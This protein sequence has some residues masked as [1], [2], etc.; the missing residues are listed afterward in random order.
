MAIFGWIGRD[1]VPPAEWDLRRRGWT[2]C[3]GHDDSRTACRHVLLCDARELAPPERRALAAADLPVWRV[4][5]LG[6]EQS[7]ERAELLSLGCV[8][9]LPVDTDLHELEARAQ[10]AIQMFDMMPRRRG[11]GPLSLELFHR[12][13]R[14]GTR[15]LGLH[16][17]EFAL[18]W[19]LSETP[20]Q[21]VTRKQLIV[22]VWRMSHDPE[23]NS[24]EVHV[25]RLRA[26]LALAGCDALVETA[27]EGGYRLAD[28]RSLMPTGKAPQ[29][30]TFESY[31]YEPG[32]AKQDA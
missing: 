22:D 20:G 4:M 8:D 29:P 10:R 6:V 26:K 5:M 14:H 11:I 1:R 9:A 30:G 25:S 13:A 12:D 7:S 16:P 27:L 18:L 3:H 15:W 23:T 31:L 24:V 17:R 32:W 2:L 28:P 21:R 19:R